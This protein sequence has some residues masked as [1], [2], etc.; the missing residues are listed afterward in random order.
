MENHIGSV[1][2][3]VKI[4]RREREGLK[5]TR[6]TTSQAFWAADN[7]LPLL[8][9][10]HAFIVYRG[11][12]KLNRLL[13]LRA[14]HSRRALRSDGEF[15]ARLDALRSFNR[16]CP[17]PFR[18]AAKT[19]FCLLRAGFS[20]SLSADSAQLSSDSL[21]KYLSSIVGAKMGPSCEALSLLGLASISQSLF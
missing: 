17:R 12:T 20:E 8:V 13:Q 7:R 10:T 6:A 2:Q 21:P 14:C 15:P 9:R 16:T 1:A 4:Q 5:K 3:R 11:L 19:R 18:L